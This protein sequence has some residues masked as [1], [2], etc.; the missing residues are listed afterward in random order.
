[1]TPDRLGNMVSGRGSWLQAED[2]P[3]RGIK[4]LLICA[5]LAI[6]F[7][8][9]WFYAV[10]DT[11]WEMLSTKHYWSAEKW[12]YGGFAWQ[13]SET[14]TGYRTLQKEGLCDYFNLYPLQET[15]PVGKSRYQIQ[16]YPST[17]RL[18]VP[19]LLYLLSHLIGAAISVW[20]GFWLVSVLLWLLT[21]F[22]AYRIARLF[23]GDC[24]AP[25]FSALLVAAYPA[26]TLTFNGIKL[27]PLG[28]TYLLLGIYI[29]ER[30]LSSAKVPLKL[31]G[32]TVLAFWGMFANGGWFFLAAFIFS[33][34]WWLH[35]A[36]RWGT[37]TCLI[38]AVVL[39]RMWLAGLAKA[40][41][42]PSVEEQL[43]FSFHRMSAESGRWLNAWWSH[44]DIDQLKFANFR[45]ATFFTGFLPL[46]GKSFLIV[47]A[48]LLFLALLGVWVEIRSRLFIFLVIPMLLA[49]HSGHIMGSYI[50]H[51]GYMS[52]PAGMMTIF[53]ASGTLNWLI[54]RKTFLPRIV[55]LAA[56]LFIGYT[57]TDIKKQVGLYYG[58][59]PDSYQRKLYIYYG[60]EAS[61]LSY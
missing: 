32:L 3:K 20:S 49:G 12:Y 23:Y 37:L 11:D 35:R 40:Y 18:G 8:V 31:I 10:P 36:S 39:A 57:F 55:A 15:G 9:F 41:H 33:R 22:L 5:L 16:G 30:H 56:C 17:E 61:H 59:N 53:A 26:L 38:A 13:I 25:W 27:Q 43:G 60:N 44:R 51:Y 34:A 14:P 50:Y 46:I 24:Y 58:G 19:F 7:G 45:G 54:S 28:T 47:H 2:Q 21:I 42:L 1:M 52:F 6:I 29:F 4:L 48:P